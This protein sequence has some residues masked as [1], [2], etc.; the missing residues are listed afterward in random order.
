MGDLTA[1]PSCVVVVERGVHEALTVY[2][3]ILQAGFRAQYLDNCVTPRLLVLR[4]V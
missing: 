4:R 3:R 1:C 2:L